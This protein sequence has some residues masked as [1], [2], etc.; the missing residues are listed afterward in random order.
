[1][2]CNTIYILNK[3]F[4]LTFYISKNTEKITH[5]KKYEAAQRFPTLIINQHIRMISEG[6]CDTEDWKKR[7]RPY[8]D[9]SA[10]HVRT[11]PW[12]R[13]SRKQVKKTSIFKQKPTRISCVKQSKINVT[14][15]SKRN[16]TTS[17]SES[18]PSR[19]L[20][21]SPPLESCSDIYTGPISCLIITLLFNV[22]FL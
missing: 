19:S 18:S 3:Q 7:P 8:F 4:F 15:L 20:S 21:F 5:P 13:R 1:M 12:Q 14:H 10:P 2:Y 6:S 16:N 9:T 11:H 17:A 22:L